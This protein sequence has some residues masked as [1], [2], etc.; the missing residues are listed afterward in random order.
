M[1]TSSPNYHDQAPTHG[2]LYVISGCEVRA[3]LPTFQS[4]VIQYHTILYSTLF[5][6]RLIQVNYS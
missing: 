2:L 3:Y 4:R 1:A 6:Y 5:Y